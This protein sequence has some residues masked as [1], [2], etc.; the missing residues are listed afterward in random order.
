[1]DRCVLA[2]KARV[3]QALGFN[4]AV[5]KKGQL[6]D[7]NEVS[8]WEMWKVEGGAS[9][10]SIT[11]A[12]SLLVTC[13]YVHNLIEYTLDGLVNREIL[14]QLKDDKFT[15]VHAIQLANCSANCN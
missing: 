9:E 8:N 14:L 4:A 2:L 5:Y 13:K 10:L 3:W 7:N 15:A 11:S 1:M 12:N 6:S